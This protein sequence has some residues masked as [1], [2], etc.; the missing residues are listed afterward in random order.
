MKKIMAYIQDRLLPAVTE[1]HAAV[2]DRV[3]IAFAVLDEEGLVTTQKMVYLEELP[4]LRR[5]NP[6]LEILLSIGGAG[7]GGFSLMSRTAEKRR[8]FVESVIRI[9]RELR[10]DGIDLDWEFPTHNWAGDADPSDRQNFTHLLRELREAFDEAGAADGKRYFLTIAAGTGQWFIDATEVRE[11]IGYLDELML[12]T[13]DMRG[14]GQK[15][16]GHHAGLYTAPGDPMVFSTESAIEL[17]RAEG[18]PDEKIII[19]AAF[20]SRYWDEVPDLN[21]GL[22]M[23]AAKP[24]GEFGPNYDQLLSDYI[25]K[26]GYVRYWDEESQAPYLFNGSTFISYDDEQSVQSKCDYIK[27]ENLGGLMFWVYLDLP[28]NPMIDMM[29]QELH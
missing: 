28:E 5:A 16:T 27:K 20:Y 11:Y 15:V 10:L 21:H 23:E 13:Y 26:N 7:A 2:F 12:M 29:E 14:F 6:D 3:Q 22:F 1:A 4:R 25:D 24:G 18:V 19:G 17:L 8:P 9:M